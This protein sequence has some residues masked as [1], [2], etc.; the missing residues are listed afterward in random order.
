MRNFFKNNNTED[1]KVELE[2]KDN[3]VMAITGIVVLEVKDKDVSIDGSSVVVKGDIIVNGNKVTIT[4]IS[5]EEIHKYAETLTLDAVTADEVV[6]HVG[7]GETLELT[8]TTEIATVT[9][10]VKEVVDVASTAKVT[11]AIVVNAAETKVTGAGN[12]AKVTINAVDVVVDATDIA[13]VDG[14]VKPEITNTV[15]EAV[16]NEETGRYDVTFKVET[17]NATKVEFKSEKLANGTAVK[18]N[19]VDNKA[20]I[21]LEPSTTEEMTVEVK[22]IYEVG[23]KTVETAKTTIKITAEEYPEKK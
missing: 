9:V 15:A 1:Y 18:V 16:Y 22:A 23:N 4:D 5:A 6:V 10:N 8:G 7:H 3:K 14:T 19:V 2:I 21:V 12:I 11:T 17:K 13:N 20:E